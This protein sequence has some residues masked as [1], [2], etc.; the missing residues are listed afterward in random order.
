MALYYN[1][2]RKK[3]KVYID[4][5]KIPKN[6]MCINYL[7]IKNEQSSLILRVYHYFDILYGLFM[8][9]RKTKPGILMYN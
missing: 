7:H 2:F 8:T 3:I 4:K 5:N 1:G 9:H 6:Y